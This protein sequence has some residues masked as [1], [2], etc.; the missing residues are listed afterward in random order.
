[1]RSPRTENVSAQNGEKGLRR[2]SGWQGL[3]KQDSNIT[4][5]RSTFFECAERRIPQDTDLFF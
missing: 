1:M 4:R 5:R 3:L 2:E